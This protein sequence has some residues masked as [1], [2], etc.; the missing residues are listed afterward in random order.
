MRGF[1]APGRDG[2]DQFLRADINAGGGGVD[3]CAERTLRGGSLVVFVILAFA[4]AH[5]L[6]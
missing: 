6:V 4:F 5:G 1:A 2:G 3:G